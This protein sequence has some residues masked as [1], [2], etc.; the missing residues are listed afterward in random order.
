MAKKK[1]DM[2]SVVTEEVRVWAVSKKYK[3]KPFLAAAPYNP[4]TRSYI[5]GQEDWTGTEKNDS[6]HIAVNENYAITNGQTLILQKVG[7]TYI[8]NFDYAMYCFI[9]GLEEVAESRKDV[10]KTHLFYL[11]N[12][13]SE[14]RKTLNISKARGR[15]Y[16]KLS[17]VVTLS[18]MRDMLFFFGENPTNMSSNIAEA[19]LYKRADENPVSVIDY[20]TNIEV[21]KRITVVKK[22]LQ[23][24][25]LRRA[26]VNGY[27]MYGNNVIGANEAEAAAFLYDDKNNSI[28]IPVISEIQKIE[29][30]K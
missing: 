4:D 22:A 30:V 13:E 26:E 11:E 8:K 25:I 21:N 28:Y 18:D 19:S 17:E 3:V 24:K 1:I 15:A 29:G 10:N 27:I 14:A 16:A 9:K 5:T 2:D 6:L 7:D 23:Y 12:R 20:F